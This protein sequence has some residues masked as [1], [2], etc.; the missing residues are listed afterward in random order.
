MQ[1]LGEVDAGFHDVIGRRPVAQEQFAADEE[2]RTVIGAG[3]DAVAARFGDAD[4][5]APCDREIVLRKGQE[6]L[7]DAIEGDRPFDGCDERFPFEFGIPEIPD[8]QTVCSQVEGCPR[9][10]QQ[11]AGGAQKLNACVPV[12]QTVQDG[13][14]SEKMTRHCT[15]PGLGEPPQPSQR[16]GGAGIDY[17]ETIGKGA[18]SQISGIG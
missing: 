1:A 17:P 10:K 2:V 8:G 5:T 13:F 12:K 18:I 14:Q 7:L 9:Q 3:H 6:L 11:D 16:P 4:K 15:D